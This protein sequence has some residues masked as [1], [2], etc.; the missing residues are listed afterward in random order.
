VLT[1]AK[2]RELARAYL[3]EVAFGKDLAVDRAQAPTT[4]PYV[5]HHPRPA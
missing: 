4:P 2:A 1:I 3:T 5:A